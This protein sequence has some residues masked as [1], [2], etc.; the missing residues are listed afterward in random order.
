MP[1][2]QQGRFSEILFAKVNVHGACS[3]LLFGADY[4]PGGLATKGH[5]A[6]TLEEGPIGLAKLSH[7]IPTGLP[8][9]CCVLLRLSIGRKAASHQLGQISPSE[10]EPPQYFVS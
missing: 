8:G 2:R 10:P 6:A 9:N 7:R 5:N 1:P 3:R 4:T